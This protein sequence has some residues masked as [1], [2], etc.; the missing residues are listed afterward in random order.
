ME[1]EQFVKGLAKIISENRSNNPRC[2]ICNSDSLL[3]ENNLCKRCEALSKNNNEI[4]LTFKQFEYFIDQIDELKKIENKVDKSLKL[5]DPDFNEFKLGEP[6]HIIIDLLI[7]SMNDEVQ[8]EYSMISVWYYEGFPIEWWENDKK[9][10][11]NDLK[12]LYDFFVEI[13]KEGS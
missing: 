8:H 7:A 2:R 5:F 13:N 1:P 6:I 10:M 4:G 3:T 12:G 9:I 11:I